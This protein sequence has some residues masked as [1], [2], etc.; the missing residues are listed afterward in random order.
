M[1]KMSDI[2]VDGNLDLYDSEVQSL[3][4]ILAKLQVKYQYRKA[5][6]ENLNSLQS[7]AMDSME[8]AGFIATVSVFDDNM[9]PSLPPAI[10]IHGRVDPHIFDPERQE[11]EAKKEIADDEQVKEFTKKGGT[12]DQHT[13]IKATVDPVEKQ[14]ED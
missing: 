8:R 5:S 1:S 13:E 9:Q 6:F 4:G 10:T 14:V 2:T 11:W 12:T 3:L 7:E